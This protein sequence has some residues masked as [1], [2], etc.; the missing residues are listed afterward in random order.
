MNLK[1]NKAFTLAEILITLLIVGVVFALTLPMIIQNCKKYI[2]ENRLK[3]FYSTIN[4]V[5]NMAKVDYGDFEHWD[6][7]SSLQYDTNIN[8]AKKYIVPYTSVID[9]GHGPDNPFG[10]YVMF[11]NGS[12]LRI[13]SDSIMF[14]PDKKKIQLQGRDCFAFQWETNLD[15]IAAKKNAFEPYS[16][17][18]FSINED[19]DYNNLYNTSYYSCKNQ[20]ASCASDQNKFCT[21]IIYKNGWKIPYDYPI[22]F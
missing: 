13:Q 8:W 6:T 4:Q 18:R 19:L 20:I 2:V 14:Y 16:G 15:R 5:L 11:K 1:F 21:W 10:A 17:N 7:M 22:K 3:T 9:V 12:M